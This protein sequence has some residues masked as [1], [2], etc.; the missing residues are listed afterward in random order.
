METAV[1]LSILQEGQIAASSL[2][3]R[4]IPPIARFDARSEQIFKK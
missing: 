1:S 3:V 2:Q 4:E